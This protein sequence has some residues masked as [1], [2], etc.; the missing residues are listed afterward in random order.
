MKRQKKSGSDFRLWYCAAEILQKQKTFP[1]FYKGVLFLVRMCIFCIQQPILII[2]GVRC[3]KNVELTKTLWKYGREGAT[4]AA[5][6][7][8]KRIWIGRQKIV[9]HWSLM[10]GSFLLFVWKYLH[11]Q[12]IRP[13]KIS[14]P[15]L[16]S[17]L[18]HITYIEILKLWKGLTIVSI[19]SN[20]LKNV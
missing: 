18:L 14:H 10:L 13:V 1:S 12:C 20:C 3:P 11:E 4:K 19:C 7:V 17:N 6:L 16:T 5:L 2:L 9:R 15:L 8:R